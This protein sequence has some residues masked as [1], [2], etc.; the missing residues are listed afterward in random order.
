MKNKQ[1]DY[2]TYFEYEGKTIWVRVDNEPN[3]MVRGVEK[4]SGY[5]GFFD[6]EVITSE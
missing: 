2:T 4:M 5:F 3:R 1:N 6:S